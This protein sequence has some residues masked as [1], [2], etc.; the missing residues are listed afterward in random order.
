MLESTCASGELIIEVKNLLQEMSS[1]KKEA[2]KLHE[3]KVMA[4]TI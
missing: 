2:V 3:L 1:R 4:S